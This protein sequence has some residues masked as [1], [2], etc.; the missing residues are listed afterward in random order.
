MRSLMSNILDSFMTPARDL[1]EI[2][3]PHTATNAEACAPDFCIQLRNLV[4]SSIP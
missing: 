2:T 1:H 4:P 3:F